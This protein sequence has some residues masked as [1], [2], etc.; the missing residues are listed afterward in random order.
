MSGF[1][2]KI[3]AMMG[4]LEHMKQAYIISFCFSVS[5]SDL[6]TVAAVFLHLAS[7]HLENEM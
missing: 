1:M 3:T 2:A 7:R 4:D 5:L 6:P